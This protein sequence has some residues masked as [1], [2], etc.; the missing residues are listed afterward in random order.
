MAGSSPASLVCSFEYILAAAPEETCQVGC[1]NG[2]EVQSQLVAPRWVIFNCCHLHDLT[3]SWALRETEL[4]EIHLLFLGQP[5]PG[6]ISTALGQRDHPE[7]RKTVK[8]KGNNM[9]CE[10]V[11]FD[12]VK[13]EEGKMSW[14][15]LLECGV[16]KKSC[17]S[18][19]IAPC[20]REKCAKLQLSCL[21][22]VTPQVSLILETE[23]QGTLQRWKTRE[24]RGRWRI[25]EDQLS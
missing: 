2:R 9:G 15:A 11:R 20:W 24:P 10:C 3:C 19:T 22:C 13:W 14:K 1:G 18:G 7:M 12:S 4:P 25:K 5:M 16:K 8:V 17:Y 21:C 6:W 23:K